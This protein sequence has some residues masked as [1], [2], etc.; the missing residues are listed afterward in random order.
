MPDIRPLE[1][2]GARWL[3][4]EVRRLQ[5]EIDALREVRVLDHD[6]MDVT[7]KI[8]DLQNERDLAL[9]EVEQLR[10]ALAARGG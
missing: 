4:D 1:H 2:R 10:A 7:D 5:A 6:Q 3:A 8:T 9:H